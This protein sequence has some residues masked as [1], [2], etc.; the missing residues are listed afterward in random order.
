MS[1]N[2]DHETAH[3]TSDSRPADGSHQP[4][5]QPNDSQQR[6]NK[7]S[8]PESHSND[9]ISQDDERTGEGTGAKAGEYS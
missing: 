4:Q 5:N 3:Q 7:A 9:S 2:Q 8:A 6:G 1:D